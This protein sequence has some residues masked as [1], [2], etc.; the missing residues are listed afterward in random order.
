MSADLL[1]HLMAMKQD[2][3]SI[4]ISCYPSPFARESLFRSL[5]SNRR[6]SEERWRSIDRRDTQRDNTIEK[7]RKKAL[8]KESSKIGY[9]KDVSLVEEEGRKNDSENCG[10]IDL[11][12]FHPKREEEGGGVNGEVGET[13]ERERREDRPPHVKKIRRGASRW[14][15]FEYVEGRPAGTVGAE[16]LLDGEEEEGEEERE[17]EEGEG[18]GCGQC[19]EYRKV[20]LRWDCMRQNPQ[21][22]M[23]EIVAFAA[24]IRSSQPFSPGSLVIV[25]VSAFPELIR[26][27]SLPAI[28]LP[29]FLFV[30]LMI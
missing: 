5:D 2:P 21:Q 22:I 7:G 17:E 6:V 14:S 8:R 20:I 28:I 12:L 29:S 23:D 13:M 27:F 4:L 11:E 30:H 9:S 10:S 16:T 15:T 19:E 1:E 3:S 18:D 24:K 26:Y 25:S